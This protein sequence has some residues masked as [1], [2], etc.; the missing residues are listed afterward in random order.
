MSCTYSPAIAANTA[1]APLTINVSVAPNATMPSGPNPVSNTATVAG[2]GDV[3]LTNNS[4][5]DTTTI[6]L[7][8]NLTLAKSHTGDFRRGQTDAQ[9]TL[10]VTNSGFANTTGTITVVDTLPAALSFVSGTGSG[11][12]NC[13][14]AA[15]VVTCTTASTTDLAPGSSLPA[16]T[17]TVSVDPGTPLSSLT[18]NAVVSG[19]GELYITDDAASDTVNLIAPP[20]LAI[21]K[22]STNPF[23]QGSTGQYTL[24]VTNNGTGATSGQIV[25][26]DTLPTGLTLGVITNPTNWVCTYAPLTRLVE[27]KSDPALVTLAPSGSVQVVIPVTVDVNAPSSITNNA[28]VYGGSEVPGSMGDNYVSISTPVTLLPDLAVSKSHSGDFRQGQTGATYTIILRNL[29]GAATSGPVEL[30]DTVPAGL[31]IT[32]LA[33]AA[34]ASGLWTC[35]AVTAGT[36]WHCLSNP[37]LVGAGTTYTFTLTVDVAND[38][39]ISLDNHVSVN[40]DASETITANNTDD[41]TTAITQVADLRVAKSHTDPFAQG[42][43]NAS[44]LVRVTNAGTG[45]TDAPIVVTDTLPLSLTFKSHTPLSDWSFKVIS[46]APDTVVF[47]RTTALGAGQSTDL[48]LYVDVAKNAPATVTNN[49]KVGG[50]GEVIVDSQNSAADSTNVTQMPDLVIDKS[51]LA[52]FYQGQASATYSLV[53]S[54]R[55]FATTNGTVSVVDTLP[56]GGALTLVSMAGTG[57]TCPAGGLT[58]TRSDSLAPGSSY[59]AITVTVAV[60]SSAPAQ[61]TNRADV[62]GSE[63]DTTNSYDTDLTNI[64]GRFDLAIDKTHQTTSGSFSQGGTGEFYLDVSN[65]GGATASGV[66]QVTD[67]LTTGLTP[68]GPNGAHGDWICA[69][70]G[71]TVTC[72]TDVDLA[73]G[74]S[75][76]RITIPV[77]VA[78]DAAPLLANVASV[79][80]ADNEVNT[81]NN[82]DRDTITTIQAANLVIDKYHTLQ[83]RQGQVG[84][85]YS[86]KVSNIGN[87]ATNAPIVVTDTLPAG[88]TATA[89]GASG[90]TCD[91]L[92]ALR[93]TRPSLAAGTESILSLTVTVDS[94]APA[95]VT[96]KAAVS[97]GGELIIDGEN[98]DEDITDITQYADL[99][100][101]KTHTGNFTQGQTGAQYTLTVTNL[102]RASTTNPIVVQDMLPAGLT[103]TQIAGD[104]TWTCDTLPALRCTRSD[105]L[106]PGASS[107]IIVTVSVN[108]NAA[109]TLRNMVTVTGGGQVIIDNDTAFD[110]T[111]IIQRANLLLT[112]VVNPTQAVP[113]QKVDYTINVV[114]NGMGLA[115]NVVLTDILPTAFQV[116]AVSFEGVQ[117]V[118]TGHVPAYVWQVG[119][120]AQGKSGTIHISG[121]FAPGTLPQAFTNHALVTTSALEAD[122]NDNA[123]QASLNITKANSVTSLTYAPANPIE[124]QTVTFTATV[125][126]AAPGIGLPTGWLTFTHGTTVLGTTTLNANGQAIL[127]VS[128]LVPGAHT[129]TASYGG[130]MRHYPSSTTITNAIRPQSNLGIGLAVDPRSTLT[131][132]NVV[133]TISASNTGPTDAANVLV[134]LQL[135]TGFNFVSA[136]SSAGCSDQSSQVVC[137]TSS[138]AVGASTSFSVVVNVST[139]SKTGLITTTATITSDSADLVPGNNTAQATLNVNGML[140][141]YYNNFE[142]PVGAE[143]CANRRDKTPIGQ[144]QFLG[145]FGNETT[146]LKLQDLSAHSSIKVEFDLYLINTWNGNF[147][148]NLLDSEGALAPDGESGPD[149][150]V[151]EADDQ[152]ILDTTYALWKDNFQSFPS[153]YKHGNFPRFTGAT[154]NRTLGYYYAEKPMDAVYHLSFVFPH[155]ASTLNLDFSGVN[156]QSIENESWGLDNVSVT[157]F[158]QLYQLYLPTL[159]R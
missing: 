132:R 68:T 70:V 118:D 96:N 121:M 18:N 2:T 91:P 125:Q 134:T 69:V 149:R 86:L 81:A 26:S 100:I 135:P 111:T 145:Q 120:L 92:P 140:N 41:D 85:V 67:V 31:T 82:S 95:Q 114:N 47:T 108:N 25:I 71:Q 13:T 142:Q 4:S 155:S 14:A 20:N 12:N 53:V 61:V 5:T 89:F 133:Y 87:A 129:F 119:D 112:K 3:D 59:P 36:T 128:G 83:F 51:H 34:P 130:D 99:S 75:L 88:L 15:Q 60:S 32:N 37:A 23:V 103:A 143:W 117:F 35:S 6:V 152:V 144:R 1:A 50:G 146:C 62:S 126:T 153:W 49:V 19:G 38:A 147:T 148:Y 54:N 94:N 102:G 46:L 137:Q 39:P 79:T 28:Q 139:Q 159:T 8:P 66:I 80:T 157:L 98:D 27:C 97:G 150:W 93:C 58:C 109:A 110:D 101:T 21:T 106:A 104:A 90:W 11:W 105:A 72:T 29:G 64:D 57:W 24:V 16:I 154:E 136:G 78:A 44:Y 113:G 74:A 141:S 65:P 156:L 9:F 122:A 45:D 138:L 30:T 151:L 42:Q 56:A 131:G 52:N 127:A 7:M 10:T 123:A 115:T 22:T 17:L 77:T 33:E 84:A 40:V 73:G 55:G 158:G 116:S 63:S 48:T 124:G 76:S 107:S 43:V